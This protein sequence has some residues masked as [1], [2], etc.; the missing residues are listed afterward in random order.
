MRH[1]LPTTTA[2]VLASSFLL[3]GNC[4][5][6]DTGKKHHDSIPA[7]TWKDF[8]DADGDGVTEADGDCDDQ[9]PNVFPGNTEDCNGADDNCNGVVDEGMPDTDGDRI[10]DCVD[11]EECDGLDNDGDGTV[12]EGFPDSDGNGRP[13]CLEEEICDGLDNNGDGLVDEGFD[14]DSDGYTTCGTETEEPD[15][16]DTDSSVNPGAAEI[17]DDELDN[18]CDGMVDEGMWV[19]GDLAIVEV[20]T[21]PLASSD[22]YGEW[23]EVINTTD[24]SIFLNGLVITST[25]DEDYHQIVSDTL[26]GMAPGDVMVLGIS[27]DETINGGVYVD[28]QYS[29][30]IFSNESDDLLLMA[31]DLILDQVVWDDGA[32][33]PD[34]SGSTMSL[35]PWIYTTGDYFVSA[36]NDDAANWCDSVAP[37]ETRSDNGSPG[38][39]N[40]YCHSWDHDGDGYDTD[41]GDCDDGDDT[42]YPGAPEV[43]PT[44]DNDCDGEAEWAPSSLADYDPASSTLLTCDPLYLVGTGSFDP[45]G[46][47]LTY[48]WEVTAVPSGSARTTTDLITSS[49]DNPVFYPDIAGDYE[50]TLTVNDGGT[51]SLP[52]TLTLTISERGSNAD[53]VAAA[54]D[55]QSY[56]YTSTCTAGA[57]STYTCP[58]CADYD[59]SLDATGSTDADDSLL[60]YSWAITGG[61]GSSYAT[62]DDSTSATPTLSMTGLTCTYGSTTTYEV[63]LTLTVTDCPGATSTDDIVVTYSCTGS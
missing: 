6:E 36:A 45:E 26:L 42:V 23:F 13:D 34:V 43:D 11:T 52:S 51:D 21:N 2:L 38:L 62:L 44:K 29:D 3:A 53:P 40:E 1:A 31:G 16:D 7:D 24:R 8:V 41:A 49:T 9:D 56:S 58:D 10:A 25:V 47:A 57:Y 35:D 30:I 50:F 15:C 63:D 4:K 55:D 5:P 59:F 37:W 28:Y 12:D 54:G 18:D 60:L 14:A 33:M 61:S 19:A 46:D 27:E 32:T 48:A 20:M 17:E 22:Y 39:T